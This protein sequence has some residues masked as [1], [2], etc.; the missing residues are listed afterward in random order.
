MTRVLV[1][2]IYEVSVQE[3]NKL[4][5]KANLLKKLKSDQLIKLE[6]VLEEE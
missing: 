1:R 2:K 3:R 4:L 5:E 6:S